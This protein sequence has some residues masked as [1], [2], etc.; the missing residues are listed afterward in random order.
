MA[1]T[2]IVVP[3]FSKHIF[4]RQ[5]GVVLQELAQRIK[6][7]VT[8]KKKISSG[9]TACKMHFPQTQSKVNLTKHV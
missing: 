5:K 4:L 8:L 3:R 7:H 6:K 1:E 9:I 2:N